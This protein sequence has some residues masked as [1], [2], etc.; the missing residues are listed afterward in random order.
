MLVEILG[1]ILVEGVAYGTYGLMELFLDRL[2]KGWNK[3]LKKLLCVL[4]GIALWILIGYI[5][6]K[7]L[8]II[9]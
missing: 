7:I 4:L 2:Y 5:V 1:E 3:T 8:E 6:I 9:L